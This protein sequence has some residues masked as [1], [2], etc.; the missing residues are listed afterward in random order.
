[1]FDKATLELFKNEGSILACHS[2]Q[3][4]QV[5]KTEIGASNFLLGN[6]HNVASLMLRYKDVD[7]RKPENRDCNRGINPLTAGAHNGQSLDAL[8]VMFIKYKQRFLE[9]NWDNVVRAQKYSEY[10]DK[11]GPNN[12][13][14]ANEFIDNPLIK[15]KLRQQLIGSKTQENFDVQYYKQANYDLKNLDDATAV[16]H[17]FAS[18]FA[19]GRPHRW[20]VSS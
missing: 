8:E 10:I 19:E 4:E 12:S 2:T 17:F 18:G 5:Q 1:V 6:G 9:S 3:N 11:L 15:T 13:V 16:S 20:K 14:V 7:F